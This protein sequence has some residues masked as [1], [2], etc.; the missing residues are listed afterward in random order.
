MVVL[1]IG[2]LWRRRRRIRGGVHPEP[3]K[4]STADKPIV[5]DFPLPER[6]YLPLQQHLGQPAEPVVRV[7]DKVLKGQLLAAGR[8]AV[9]APVH[10]S[11]SGTVA[12]IED[13]P[14]PHPSGLPTPTIVLEPDGEDRWIEESEEIDP[15]GLTPDEIC[16][17]VDRAGIVGLGGAAFPSAVKLNLGWRTRIRTLILNGGECEPYLTCDDRLMRERA[18]EIVEGVRIMLHGLQCPTALIAIEDNKPEAYAAMQDAAM[19]HGRIEVV[20]VPSLYP[21]GWEKNLITHL[22]GKEVPAGGRPTDVGV[23][24]HNVATAYAVQQAVRYG[25]PLISRVVTVSGEA[26]ESPRNVEAPFGTLLSELLAFCRH[27]PERTA[28][29]VMGGPMMGDV[30]PHVQVPIVKR[31]SG[32]LALTPEEIQAT[33]ARPCIRCGRCV[34]ACPVGL[35]P[36]EMMSRI[37]AGQ[38][39]AAVS[40]GLR[41]CIN[42]SSCSYVCPSRIPL[43]HYFKYASGELMAR[44]EAQQK[45]E[46]TNRLAEEK[47]RR[48]ERA[49]QAAAARKAQAS[50]KEDAS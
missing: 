34:S 48:L 37:R 49:K 7:G 23:L 9:S 20:K 24:L 17:R 25:R 42:C 32:I 27:R 14:A 1:D 26:V 30:L 45:T 19:K 13:Y 33:D 29:Y 50:A 10:A 5:T 8:G 16:A 46:R 31:T 3:R 4:E 28:R 12:A 6:L 40:F 44:Q 41:D 18:A 43:V 47:R 36:L 11:T 15:F 35:L 39:D 21:M 2:A 38:F 22:T